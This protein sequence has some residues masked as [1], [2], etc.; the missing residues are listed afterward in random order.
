MANA[1]YTVPLPVNEPVQ[2]YLPGSR[3][4][5][6]LKEELKRLKMTNVE[7][8]LIIGGREIKTGKLA[9]CIIPHDHGR[10]LATFHQAGEQEIEMAVEAARQARADWAEAAWED[11]ISIFLKAAEILAGSKRYTVNAAAMLCQSKTVFQAEIDAACELTD[12]FRFNVYYAAQ[13]YEGQ[14]PYSPEGIWNRMEYRPLEGFIFAVTPFN[15]LSIAGNLP[16]APVIAGNVS[17][18]KPASTAVYSAYRVMQIFRDAGLPDGVIN[19]IP[20]PGSEIGPMALHSPDLAG[21]H[22]TGNSRTLQSMWETVGR[23]IKQYRSYPRIVGE[24]GGKDFIVAHMSADIQALSTALIRGAFEYQGQK[25]SAV[26]RAYIPAGI[27][28]KLRDFLGDELQTVK[29]GDV[30]DFSTFMGAVIDKS[31]FD[32][33]AGYIDSIRE[34]NEAKIIFG[35]RCD[36]SSGYF[37]EPTVA[38]TTD[39][40]FRTMQE[41]IFGPVLTVYVYKDDE[42]EDTLHLCDETSP[43]A[44]TGA[45][46]ARDRK[47]IAAAQ[48]ILVNAAGN[49]YINDKPTGALVGQQ[50]F[51][52]SRASG[53]NDKAGSIWNMMRWVSPRVVKENFMPQHDYRYPYM[54]RD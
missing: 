37:I 46:F 41:E 5:T 14:P 31:A 20:G 7:I 25:C 42:F 12:F 35:G 39:P 47:A 33:I 15:F 48:K 40:R 30:Q 53:T 4:R 36:D 50:P 29:M 38:L 49:F 27:W 8:P 51:G 6:L 11:R 28:R 3:E 44:L 32:R 43:Y 52:G 21:I 24:T 13:I 54:D 22:F 18:W 45:V 1:K 10:I 26:S 17:L 2:S 19:F 23:N 34:S 16:S 9:Q